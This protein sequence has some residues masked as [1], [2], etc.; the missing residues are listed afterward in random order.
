[1]VSSLP[2]EFQA[3]LIAEYARLLTR[4]EALGATIRAAE[5]QV[6]DAMSEAGELSM[7]LESVRA[8]LTAYGIAPDAQGCASPPLRLAAP[9]LP[10]SPLPLAPLAPSSTDYERARLFPREHA[11][12]VLAK[13]L[14]ENRS[15]TPPDRRRLMSAV[16][17]CGIRMSQSLVGRWTEARLTLIRRDYATERPTREIYEECRALPGDELGTFAAWQTFVCISM[18]LRRSQRAVVRGEVIEVLDEALAT[19]PSAPCAP[20]L[21]E[22]SPVETVRPRIHLSSPAAPPSSAIKRAVEVTPPPNLGDKTLL[23]TALT[24]PP[25]KEESVE[26]IAADAATIRATAE[27]WG[28]TYRGEVDLWQVNQA[29]RHR[30]ARPFA[31]LKDEV[32]EKKRRCLRCQTQFVSEGAHDRLCATCK[33]LTPVPQYTLR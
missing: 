26:P 27:L 4:D 29:A 30:G 10:P 17:H 11:E 21:A 22:I 25:K 31:L 28:V 9:A 24:L 2:T 7:Q 14:S 5:A 18:G 19:T 3:A 1:M 20:T 15:V 32:A 23:A 12:N 33:T 8:A 13:Q 16:T 6:A